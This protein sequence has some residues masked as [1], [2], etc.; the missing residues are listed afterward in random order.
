MRHPLPRD[1]VAI[2]ASAG[3]VEAISRLLKGLLRDLPASVLIVLHRSADTASHL[4]EH[5]GYRGTRR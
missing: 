5:A 3:G 2:G 1:I 4:R